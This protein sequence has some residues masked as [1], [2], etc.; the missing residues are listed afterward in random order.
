MIASD[1]HGSA[2][3]CNKLIEY[4]Q[5]SGCQK[6]VLLGDV[7][8]GDTADA[9]PR[10]ALHAYA[11]CFPHPITNESVTV[12]APLGE[13]LCKAFPLLSELAL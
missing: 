12:K 1:I 5:N 6:L 13:D 11:L 7:L 8:Y 4:Y 10:L 2:F 9:Y 3:Y